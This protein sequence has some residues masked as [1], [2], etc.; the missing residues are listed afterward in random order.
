M[1]A[2]SFYKVMK[3]ERIICSTVCTIC[4]RTEKC[5]QK[6]ICQTSN[7]HNTS[8]G[9]QF[10][11]VRRRDN[12][13]ETLL[14]FK[15]KEGRVGRVCFALEAFLKLLWG[16]NGTGKQKRMQSKSEKCVPTV[17]V[18]HLKDSH[19]ALALSVH[20]S[21]STWT[22]GKQYLQHYRPPLSL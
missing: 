1:A 8:P 2:R 17:K 3:A 6:L 22:I 13:Q 20:P 12:V 9:T 16:L 18:K 14:K 10:W 5:R 7:T 19:P 21:S 4:L 15:K 11:A